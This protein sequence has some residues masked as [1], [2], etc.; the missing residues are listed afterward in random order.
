MAV[1][2]L[3]YTDT[4]YA[5]DPDTRRSVTCLLCLIADQPF[6]WMSA[7][8]ATVTHSS[9]E[10]DFIDADAGAKAITWASSLCTEL[11]IIMVKRVPSLSPDDKPAK[12]HHD[13]N[14]VVDDRTDLHML[15]DNNWAFDIAHNDGPSM[16]T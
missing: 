16:P 6:I 11:R 2:L 4:D 1:T 14:I 12:K 10:S 9:T 8:Q 15:I 3:C 7:P 5:E 13:E